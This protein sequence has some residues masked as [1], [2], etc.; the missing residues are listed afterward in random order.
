MFL[1]QPIKGGEK[2]DTDPTVGMIVDNRLFPPPKKVPSSGA[3]SDNRSYIPSQ[4]L[5][6]AYFF[7]GLVRQCL[8]NYLEAN[9]SPLGSSMSQQV[10]AFGSNMCSGRFRAYGVSPEGAGRPA[11]LPGH[12]LLFNKKSTDDKSGKANVAAHA[13]SDVWGVLYTIP[14]T[15]LDKLDRGEGGYK[16]VRLTVRPPNGGNIDAWVYVAKK[17]TDD[18]ELRP[19]TWYKRFLIEGAREHSL[20][21]DYIAELERIDALQDADLGRDRAKRALARQA[22]L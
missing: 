2:W 19:Y 4:K 15:D 18:P 10:F 14:D 6:Y 17:P 13:G 1:S 5:P 21:D 11:M 8:V 3:I 16:R 7:E 20:P 12:R 22:Q 9:S